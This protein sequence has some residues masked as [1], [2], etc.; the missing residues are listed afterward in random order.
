MKYPVYIQ[1][2]EGTHVVMDNGN[3]LFTRRGSMVVT[4]LF[5]KYG[6][7]PSDE[8]LVTDGARVRKDNV[9]FKHN[10]EEV[11]ASDNGRIIIRDNTVYLTSNDQKIEIVNG[12]II[13][14]QYVS[15]GCVADA[16]VP[17]GEFDPFS[18]P[19][20]AEVSGY[21]HFEDIIT[22]STLL[23]KNRSPDRSS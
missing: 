16:N 7:E 20:I 22:G 13:Y 18:E 10:G 1:S 19:I 21:V 11:K 3:W 6:F 2:V 9:I 15:A 4:K 14:S 5:N 23:E 8:L 12:S 17:I